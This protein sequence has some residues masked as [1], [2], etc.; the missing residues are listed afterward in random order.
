MHFSKQLKECSYIHVGFL[1]IFIN[2]RND[3]YSKQE[4]DYQNGFGIGIRN[5]LVI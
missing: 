4:D 5:Y 3:P 1:N 2:P